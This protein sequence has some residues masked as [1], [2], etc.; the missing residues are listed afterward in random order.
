MPIKSKLR[1]AIFLDRDGTLIK[2]VHHLCDEEQVELNNTAIEAL[3]L[4]QQVGFACVVITNQSVVGREMLSLDGLQKIH[5]KMENL[6]QEHGLNIDG[7]YYS[8]HVPQTSD[9][10]KIEHFDRKPGPGMLLKAALELELNI[11]QS[12]MI[13]DSISDIFSG[14]NAGCQGNCLIKSSLYRAEWKKYAE[15]SFIANNLLE[16]ASYIVNCTPALN[17]SR[18]KPDVIHHC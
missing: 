8:T 5:I 4:L 1:P 3:S 15:I 16:A 7:I 2:H 14:V 18:D 10:T 12:W 17:S 13:G 9:L 11:A 6:L